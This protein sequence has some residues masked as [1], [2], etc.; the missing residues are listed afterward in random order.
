MTATTPHDTR[1][2]LQSN[3]P[4]LMTIFA[5]PDDETFGVAGTLA[6]A[7]ES[8]HPVAVVSATRGEAGEIADPALATKEN[9]AEV[10]EEELRR[11]CAA[12]G[13]DHVYFLD[14]IDGRLAE[15]NEREAVG[16]IVGHLRRFRPDVV[17]TFAANGGYGHV[18][19]MA[20][21]RYVVAAIPLAADPA[22]TSDYTVGMAPH[23]VRKL[24]YSSIPRERVL[25]MRAQAREQGRDFIPGGN[26]ATLPVEEMGT[27]EAEITTR[28]RLSDAEFE[29]KLKAILCHATQLPADNPWVSSSPEQLRQIMG[30]E[31]FQ[32]APPPLSDRAYPTP[33]DDLFAGL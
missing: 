32:L 30:A 28:T 5:H 18:D 4:R 29:R 15:V 21:H 17:V 6:R 1:P 19:H 12:V 22:Y 26:A 23:R 14:Y 20:I 8:G 9:L 11:A 3:K 7:A 10:R 16:R 27:P 13:V 2:A 24:Y 25:A 33:E 31:S